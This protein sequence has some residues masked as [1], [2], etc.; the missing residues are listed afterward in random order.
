MGKFT[1]LRALFSPFKPFKLK[2]YFG[3]ITIGTPYFYPRNWVK[4]TNQ[5]VIDAANESLADKKLI[6]KTF[7]EWCEYYRG[8]QK[9][10]PKKF[11]FDFV[12]LGWK[13]KW[14]DYRFEWAPL[15]SFV[16]LKWQIVVM[17]IA[18]EQ[19]HYWESWL[20]YYRDTDKSK[21]KQ[22]RIKE[23]RE[24]APQI[25]T[26]HKDGKTEK[27]DYYNLILRKKYL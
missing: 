15:W 13:T 4:Y 3:E 16:F 26:S 18:P 17:F 22:E 9:A 1:Y 2:W 6:K 19:S 20:Y 8:H 21:S 12:P 5:D 14:D 24:K 25:W 11:G 23:C 7:D 27:I 10:V